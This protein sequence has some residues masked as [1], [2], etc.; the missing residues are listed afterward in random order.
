MLNI[1]GTF[2]TCLTEAAYVINELVKLASV[3]ASH[4]NEPVTKDGKLVPGS[5]TEAFIKV[6]KVPAH[7]P[8]FGRTMEFDGKRACLASC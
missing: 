3:V 8:L 7:L 2:T 1:G 6:V 4:A 5:K